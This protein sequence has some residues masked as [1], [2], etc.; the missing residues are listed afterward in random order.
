MI[1]MR[2]SNAMEIEIDDASLWLSSWW[3]WRRRRSL[4]D[5]ID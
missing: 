5:V 2:R 4:I 1:E 3:W